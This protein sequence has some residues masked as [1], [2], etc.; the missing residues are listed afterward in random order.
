MVPLFIKHGGISVKAGMG[1][2][3]LVR[4]KSRRVI[5]LRYVARM[6]EMINSDECNVINSVFQCVTEQTAP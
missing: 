6:D 5:W 1:G 4:I 2:L 3:I